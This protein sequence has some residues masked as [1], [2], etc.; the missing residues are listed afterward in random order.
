MLILELKWNDTDYCE[1]FSRDRTWNI[2]AL[3]VSGCGFH[4]CFKMQQI[5]KVPESKQ[6]NGYNFAQKNKKKLW[7]LKFKVR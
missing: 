2:S 5:L 1:Y 6:E 3:Y 7:A 4:I